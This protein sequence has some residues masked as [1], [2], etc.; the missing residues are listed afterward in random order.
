MCYITGQPYFLNRH[1]EHVIVTLLQKVIRGLSILNNDLGI[2]SVMFIKLLFYL[3][4]VRH[5][6]T[7]VGVNIEIVQRCSTPQMP[8]VY[9]FL[10]GYGYIH[11]Y[12]ECTRR[13]IDNPI[14]V[15]NDETITSSLGL[16]LWR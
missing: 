5:H 14:I 12:V 2:L 9:H 15:G 13:T 10:K 16:A 3:E 4:R 1:L 11:I 7:L 6:P 8:S